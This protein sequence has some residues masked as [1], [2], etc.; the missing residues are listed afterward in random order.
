MSTWVIMLMKPNT[1]PPCTFRTDAL[2]TN[3]I[4]PLERSSALPSN[5]LNER[6]RS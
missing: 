6:L 2:M 1:S 3:G 4:H 5:M